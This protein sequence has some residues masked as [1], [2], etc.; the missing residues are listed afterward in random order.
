MWI[1]MNLKTSKQGLK[2]KII[3]QRSIIEVR[4]HTLPLDLAA[5]RRVAC[6]QIAIEEQWAGR[7]GGDGS[8]LALLGL[9]SRQRVRIQ[10]TQW[11]L[12]RDHTVIQR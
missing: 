3:R 11:L 4:K 9:Q 8:R 5:V 6:T 10:Y 7:A 2:R 12:H 1:E